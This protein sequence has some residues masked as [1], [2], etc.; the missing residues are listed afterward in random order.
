MLAPVKSLKGKA[1]RM[2]TILVDGMWGVGDIILQRAV[3]RELMKVNRVILATGNASMFHDLVDRGLQ[4]SMIHNPR[5]HELAKRTQAKLPHISH[6]MTIT[7]TADVV[8]ASGSI[9]AAQFAS[10]GLKMPPEPDF[11]LPIPS[12]WSA[13]A[14]LLLSNWDMRGKPLMI[15]RPIVLNELW[16]RIPRSP[17]PAAYADLYR[18]IRD[19][20]FVVSIADLRPQSREWIVGPEQLTDVQLHHA[21]L[22]F[23]TLA[24][25]FC[26]ASLIFCNPGFT[27]VLAQAVGTP[28]ITVYG[29]HESSRTTQAVGSHLAPT[30]SIDTMRPCDCYLPSHDCDKT[31]DLISARARIEEFITRYVVPS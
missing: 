22:P 13:A 29:G 10:V 17:D 2:T 7:Y 31:I 8:K 9:L 18:R 28:A 14:R 30:L 5:I 3:L 4:L 11:S 20:F 26:E 1:A 21:D 6:R 25:L 19:R 15:Y 27:P 24:A 23:E 16:K 12:A